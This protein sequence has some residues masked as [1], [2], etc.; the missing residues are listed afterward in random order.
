M[1]LSME[2]A[3]SAVRFSLGKQTSAEEIDRAVGAIAR[4]FERFAK[5]KE[6]DRA[7]AVA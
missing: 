4:V 1:G 6:K 7:Y 3:K 5:T 2:R